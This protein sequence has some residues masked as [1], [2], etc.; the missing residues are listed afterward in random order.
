VTHHPR[1]RLYGQRQATCRH[2]NVVC[3]LCGPRVTDAGKRMSDIINAKVAFTPWDQLVHSWMAF[4]LE[5]GDS[6]GTLY[7]TRTDAVNHQ[8]DEKLCAYFFMRQAQGGV[9]PTD[10]QLFL[11]VH[12]QIYDSGGRMAESPQDVLM[13]T[14]GYDILMGRID[15][16]AS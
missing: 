7:D 12:R 11:N 8:L 1:K 5:N 16:Y 3:S 10:C 2:G 6:D 4:K 14:R 13:S 15:P 9:N